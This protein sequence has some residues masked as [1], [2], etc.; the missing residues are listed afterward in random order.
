MK[1][2]YWL[3]LACAVCSMA[4]AEPLG[5]LFFTPEQR[6]QLDIARSHRSRGPTVEAVPDEEPSPAVLTY[7]GIVRR[8][9]GRST[10]WI[11][12][13]PVPGTAAAAQLQGSARVQQDGAVTVTLPQ[14]KRSV[15][16]RVGQSIELGSGEVTESYMRRAPPQRTEAAPNVEPREPAFRLRRRWPDDRNAA[17]P[18]EPH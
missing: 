16:L 13:R 1:L 8:D 5:R 7:S 10:V 18:E 15:R 14:Q 17:M 9:D 6:A 3:L 4:Q 2:Q 12:D 11:N